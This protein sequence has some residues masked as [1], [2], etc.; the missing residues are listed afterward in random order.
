MR[1]A[2]FLQEQQLLYR[3]VLLGVSQRA[4]GTLFLFLLRAS[5]SV[6]RL[7]LLQRRRRDDARRRNERLAVLRVELHEEGLPD[8][9][10]LEKWNVLAWVHVHSI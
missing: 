2:S 5:A 10:E 8:L 9:D 6:G 3:C 4:S 7:G 1:G